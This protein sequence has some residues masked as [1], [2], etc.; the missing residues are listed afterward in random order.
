MVFQKVLFFIFIFFNCDSLYARLN[1]HYEAYGYKTKKHNKIT[2][3]R[4]S[5]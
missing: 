3:F 1:S 5:V 4:K 2:A